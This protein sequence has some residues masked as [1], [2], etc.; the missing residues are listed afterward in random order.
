M[1]TLDLWAGYKSK[2]KAHLRNA[3]RAMQSMLAGAD[4][5]DQMSADTVCAADGWFGNGTDAAVKA[6]QRANG[7]IP[8]GVCGRLTW[9]GLVAVGR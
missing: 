1:P 6:F 8:D 2:D 4:H 5:P 3:V 7:L 9:A